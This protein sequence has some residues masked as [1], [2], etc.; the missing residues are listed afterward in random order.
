MRSCRH[1]AAQG[2]KDSK[3]IKAAETLAA[4][5]PE[6]AAPREQITF[7]FPILTGAFITSSQWDRRYAGWHES[8]LETRYISA[9][10]LSICE[11]EEQ[12]AQCW[13]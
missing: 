9:S 6:R 7:F 4:I 8:A 13:L 5:V 3:V 10:Q 2:R 1:A 11:V 12:A